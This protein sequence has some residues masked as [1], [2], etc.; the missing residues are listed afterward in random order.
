MGQS[1]SAVANPNHH[2][3]AVSGARPYGG[4]ANEEDRLSKLSILQLSGHQR[5]RDGDRLGRGPIFPRVDRIPPNSHKYLVESSG[6]ALYLRQVALVFNYL[7]SRYQPVGLQAALQNQQPAV[8]P[9]V[10][11]HRL[12]YPPQQNKLCILC[13]E[14]VGTSRVQPACAQL[15]ATP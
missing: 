9:F 14:T 5:R 8:N 11:V 12:Q 13:R 3:F 15:R 6:I 1:L 2:K 4:C 7:N 10:N